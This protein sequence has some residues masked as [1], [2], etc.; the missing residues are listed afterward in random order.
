MVGNVCAAIE[1]G[2]ILNPAL[3]ECRGEILFGLRVAI[4]D[5]REYSNG[6]YQFGGIIVAFAFDTEHTAQTMHGR[7]GKDEASSIGQTVEPRI[8]R[9]SGT[10]VHIDHVGRVERHKRT[11]TFHDRDIRVLRKICSGARRQSGSYSMAVTRPDERTRCAMTA[12]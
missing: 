12:E 4:S 8:G 10:G 3:F 11:I 1:S 9:R 2:T 5:T 7:E 6:R